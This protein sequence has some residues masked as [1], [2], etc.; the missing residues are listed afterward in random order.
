M[1]VAGDLG[2][3][4]AEAFLVVADV[5]DRHAGEM[6][7]QIGR[8]R[9]RPARLAG[10]HHAVGGHQGLTRDARIGIRRQIGIE[11]CVAEPIG[12]LVGMALRDRLGGEQELAGIAHEWFL[13]CRGEDQAGAV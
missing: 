2:L 9:R 11:D 8:H 3:L 7:Q 10:E 4:P 1:Q 13:S 6:G 5:V 12:D